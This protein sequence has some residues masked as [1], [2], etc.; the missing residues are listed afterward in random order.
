MHIKFESNPCWKCGG[1][2][3]VS[4]SYANGVCFTC[5]GAGFT[6]T[7]RGKASRA[8]FEAWAKQALYIPVAD[9]TVGQ[10]VHVP[11]QLASPAGA[12]V[13]FKRPLE[14]VALGAMPT[15]PG[16][17]MDVTFR[18]KL[19]STYGGWLRADLEARTLT[20]TVFRGDALRRAATADELR[21]IAPTLGRGAT[22]VEDAAQ[23]AA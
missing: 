23:V 10:R 1:T 21:A 15:E 19:T 6:Y 20:V 16:H 17:G 8:R 12:M 4:F 3:R 7:R 13:T 22:L 5:S 2:G 9:L 14:I 18:A 11:A